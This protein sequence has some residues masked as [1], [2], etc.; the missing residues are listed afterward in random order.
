[1]VTSMMNWFSG[2]WKQQGPTVRSGN[3]K[4]ASLSFSQESPKVRRRR[5]PKE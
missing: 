5:H 3:R 2:L 1:M 4:G